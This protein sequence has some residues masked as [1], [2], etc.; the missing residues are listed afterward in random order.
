[1]PSLTHEYWGQDYC[2]NFT[3]PNGRSAAELA[4]FARMIGLNNARADIVYARAVVGRRAEIDTY[5]LPVVRIGRALVAEAAG[6][7]QACPEVSRATSVDLP[8]PPEFDPCMLES[9]GGFLLHLAGTEFCGYVAERHVATAQLK[10]VTAA[11]HHQFALDRA[12][13]R[14]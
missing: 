3:T 11:I 1:M 13:T 6:M 7:Y 9:T 14:S 12:I 8:A 4:E 2:R 10:L 5:R